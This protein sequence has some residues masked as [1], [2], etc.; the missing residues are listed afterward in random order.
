MWGRVAL[1]P[2]L[3]GMPAVTPSTARAA[4]AS[5]ATLE[6]ETARRIEAANARQIASGYRDDDPG[7]PIDLEPQY[8]TCFHERVMPA[9]KRAETDDGALRS[10]A[11]G[12]VTWVRGV[13]LAGL[14]ASFVTENGAANASFVTGVTNAYETVALRCRKRPDPSAV[15]E[16]ISLARL[17]DLLGHEELFPGLNDDI[18]ACGMRGFEVTVHEQFTND[19]FGPTLDVTYRVFL[20]RKRGAGAGELTGTGTYRG[21][22]SGAYGK[23]DPVTACYTKLR[24]FRVGGSF[25][26][27][28]TAATMGERVYFAY[29]FMTN[30]WMYGGTPNAGKFVALAGVADDPEAAKMG[31]SITDIGF[32]LT[33]PVTRVSRSKPSVAHTCTG[34]T[35]S[36]RDVTVR[37][38]K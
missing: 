11:L 27:T 15:E 18:R 6:R 23:P 4:E 34:S 19:K 7:P 37:Q 20:R 13:E 3:A 5:C 25:G 28:A 26:A 10:A 16:L 12:Y 21:T 14:G 36:S 17:A 9:L 22:I 31:G 30:D 24:T 1:I 38:I 29:S 33:G 32:P 8:R 35:R 2:L